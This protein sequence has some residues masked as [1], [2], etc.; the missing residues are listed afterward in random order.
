MS[1]EKR[2][3]IILFF[4]ALC[5]FNNV[6]GQHLDGFDLFMNEVRIVNKNIKSCLYD[7][8]YYIA[9]NYNFNKEKDVICVSFHTYEDTFSV[10]PKHKFTGFTD[11]YLYNHNY[12]VTGYLTIHDVMVIIIG[13]N[14]LCYL[15]PRKKQIKMHIENYPPPF[16]GV[17]PYWT[18][19]INKEGKKCIL[20]E[21]NDPPKKNEFH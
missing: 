18:Y 15:K 16:D 7:I 8:V 19:R 10:Y 13:N 1:M 2:N 14:S 12:E 9:N 6:N 5:I 20:I 3:R 4:F 11:W 21:K 17:Y